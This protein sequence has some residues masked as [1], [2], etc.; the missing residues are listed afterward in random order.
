MKNQVNLQRIAVLAFALSTPAFGDYVALVHRVKPCVV[1]I[2]V[3]TDEDAAGQ[4]SGFFVSG[5]GFIMTNAHVIAGTHQCSDVA[6]IGSDGTHYRTEGL[7]YLNEDPDL[8]ILKV[9]CTS[10]PYLQPDPGDVEEGQ[11]VVVIGS[12]QGFVGTVSSGIV[13]SLRK[14]ST[15]ITAPISPGSSGSPVVSEAGAIIGVAVRIYDDEGSQNINFAV[16]LVKIRLAISS[17]QGKDTPAGAERLADRPPRPEI[18]NQEDA[19]ASLNTSYQELRSIFD[20]HSRALLRTEEIQW[21][22]QRDRF[23]DDPDCFLR[24]TMDRVH[25]LEESLKLNQ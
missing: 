13:S 17:I 22:R 18:R 14:D 24:V 20:P 10:A 11:A 3:E 4:G 7:A 21:L 1:E 15:Q 5:D 9:D 12:S 6:V 19:E 23:K 2:R 8:A 16:P 25:L